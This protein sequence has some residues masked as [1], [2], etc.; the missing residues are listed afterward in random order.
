MAQTFYERLGVAAD[1]TTDEIRAAYRRRIKETHPD[2]NSESGASDAAKRVIRAKEVLTDDTER[3]RYD[4]LGHRAYVKRTNGPSGSAS[5]AGGGSDSESD[6]RS[7]TERDERQSTVG[8]NR[9]RTARTDRTTSASA[10][11][12]R[13][14]ESV[15]GD[16]H[17]RASKRR[18]NWTDT[19][20]PYRK[21]AGKSPGSTRAQTPPGAVYDRRPHGSRLFP[22]EQ[23]LILLVL[24][25]LFY[26]VLVASA[27]FPPFPLLMNVAIGICVILTVGYLLS[28]PEVGVSVFG[29]WAIVG[30]VALSAMPGVTLV[31][32]LG[33][34]V[35]LTTWA[36][37]GV[38]LL[39]L[40][41]TR[42]GP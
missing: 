28:I 10:A 5:S 23:S 33:L 22:P 24:T 4:R 15:A 27:V 42:D 38:A 26:P 16:D 34:V 13:T 2:R 31:S 35:L 39:A 30:T 36:P 25:T 8:R 9:H 20:D 21:A 14:G 7:A 32:L 1:A 37:L 11:T 19:R 18:P 3:A 6:A 12:D 41:V 17:E 29:F 40:S